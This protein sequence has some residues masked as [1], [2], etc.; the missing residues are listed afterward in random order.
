MRFAGQRMRIGKFKQPRE[1][2]ESGYIGRAGY[3][4]QV[5][6]LEQS[7]AQMPEVNASNFVKTA[8]REFQGYNGAFPEFRK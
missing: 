4:P 1:E 5:Q 7:M 3:R 8:E 2:A 6:G